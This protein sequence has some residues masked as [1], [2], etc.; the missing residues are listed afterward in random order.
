MGKDRGS[1]CELIEDEKWVFIDL[2]L[3]VYGCY[4][5]KMKWLLY[6]FILLSFA[7]KAQDSKRVFE[8]KQF[9]LQD[10]AGKPYNLG[11]LKGKLV[12]VD[13][14]FPNCQPC[15]IGLA[16]GKLMQTQLQQMDLDSNLQY[17]TICFE[18]SKEN[19]LKALHTLNMP[20]AIHLYATANIYKATLV[21]PTGYPRYRIFNIEGILE[22]IAATAPS[23]TNLA[24]ASFY[25]MAKGYSLAKT[26]TIVGSIGTKTITKENMQTLVKDSLL[27]QF[28]TT[29]LQPQFGD[30]FMKQKAAL[31][32]DIYN[33]RTAKGIFDWKE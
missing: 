27:Q 5:Y 4:L 31:Q 6:F 9:T 8:L 28:Y 25:L 10:T 21:N 22:N 30:V 29:Y 15:R 20:N 12:Y 26:K 13:C 2:S 19:W 18:E 11:S 17:V 23:E 16:Y 7:A 32:N 14:W 33:T 24:E 3:N 1:S